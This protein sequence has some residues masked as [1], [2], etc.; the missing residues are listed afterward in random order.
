VVVVIASSHLIRAAGL[1]LGAG[2]AVALLVAAR[3]AAELTAAP[4]SAGIT[5]PTTG[6]L[7]VTPAAPKRALAAE[8]IRPG[9][10]GQQGSFSIRNQTGTELAVSFAADGGST[11]LDGLLRLRLTAGEALA[12][13]TLQGL[14]KGTATPLTLPSGAQREVRVRAWIPASISSGY[15][16]RR[17][18][19]EL[20]PK[21]T[22]VGG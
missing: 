22:E 2:L 4:A 7:E 9:D 17:A 5:V 21:V 13:T 14:R 11:E 8:S 18:E 12:D 1:L 20:M 19:F 10:G 15:A 3:P 6:E 16:G